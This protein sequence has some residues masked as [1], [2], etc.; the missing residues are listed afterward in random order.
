MIIQPNPEPLGLLWCLPILAILFLFLIGVF[1]F[2]TGTPLLVAF[3]PPVFA[4]VGFG[5]GW[6]FRLI[7]EFDRE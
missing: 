6:V 7:Q 2:W 3:C 4:T 1:L 5:L